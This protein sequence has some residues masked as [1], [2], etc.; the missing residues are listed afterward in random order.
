MQFRADYVETEERG[1]G[2]TNGIYRATGGYLA[3]LANQALHPPRTI[4]LLETF[5]DAIAHSR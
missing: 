1:K 2:K 4:K 3:S 5:G